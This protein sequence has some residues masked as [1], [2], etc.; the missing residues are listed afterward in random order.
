MNAIIQAQSTDPEQETLGDM[1]RA[2]SELY[3]NRPVS[4]AEIVKQLSTDDSM[5]IRQTGALQDL[6]DNLCEFSDRATA[7][8]KSLGRVLKYRAGRIVSGKLLERIPDKHTNVNL[9]R[10]VEVD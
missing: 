5:Y 2:W 7:S 4:S 6:R 8:P 10:V 9:W 3:G 1:L